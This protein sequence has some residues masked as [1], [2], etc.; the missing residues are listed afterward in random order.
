MDASQTCEVLVG[1]VKNSNLNFKLNES[2]FSV[3]IDLKKSFIRNKDGVFRTSN[4]GG[5]SEPLENTAKILENENET[6][7]TALAQNEHEKEVFTLIINNLQIKLE[8]AKS[9]LLETFSDK[10]HLLDA[11]I[12][13]EKELEEKSV[14]LVGM[15]EDLNK[16]KTENDN[17]NKDNQAAWQTIKNQE[18]EIKNLKGKHE[19]A[20]KNLKDSNLEIDSWPKRK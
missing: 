5:I 9:E 8:K 20:N 3:S 16:F 18:K 6:L 17:L 12:D 7:R 11:K 14:K 13:I 15:N 10:R 2:P 1:F 4:L 19:K